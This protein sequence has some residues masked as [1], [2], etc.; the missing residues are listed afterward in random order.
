MPKVLEYYT[1]KAIWYFVF[2]PR[3]CNENRAHVHVGKKGQDKFAKIWLEPEISVAK[4]GELTDKQIKE[5]L[6]ITNEQYALLISRWK[7]YKEHK[8]FKTKTINKKK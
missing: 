7:A 5:V 2:Y 8:S 1:L 3:D 4:K 6:N